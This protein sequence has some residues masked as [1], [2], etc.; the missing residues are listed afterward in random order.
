MTAYVELSNLQVALVALL[1]FVNGL[2]S[3]TLRLGM[4]KTLLWAACRTILQLLLIG[5]ILEW[6]FSVDRWYVVIGLLS[7]MTMVAGVTAAQRNRYRVPGLWFNTIISIWAGC[8]LVAAYGLAVLV[9]GS[10]PW[11]QPQYTIP[12]MGMILGNTMNGTSIGLN[13]LTETLIKERDQV[14]MALALGASRWEAA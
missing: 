13:S 7:V 9:H 12:L 10:E 8:W 1:I 3:L 2:I 11:Y 4:E 5:L 14:E 6:V